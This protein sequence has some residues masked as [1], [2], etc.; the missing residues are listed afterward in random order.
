MRRYFE[1]IANQ[2]VAI[3]FEKK[4][5]MGV[6]W[7]ASTQYNDKFLYSSQSDEFSTLYSM[8]DGNGAWDVNA[9][10]TVN[11]DCTST[12]L[13]Y[14]YDTSYEFGYGNDVGAFLGSV[15]SGAGKWYC[16]GYVSRSDEGGPK[17]K[18]S[19]SI[20]DPLNGSLRVYETYDYYSGDIASGINDV[21]TS[22]NAVGF[23]GDDIIGGHGI[24]GGIWNTPVWSSLPQD[25]DYEEIQITGQ[26][27]TLYHCCVLGDGESV[28]A[29][30]SIDGIY[31]LSVSYVLLHGFN[32]VESATA[33]TY[34]LL[35][36]V[37][38]CNSST[39]SWYTFGYAEVSGQEIVFVTASHVFSP[40]P[41]WALSFIHSGWEEGPMYMTQDLDNVYILYG[42]WA[43]KGILCISKI[44]GT[45]VWDIVGDDSTC[46]IDAIKI[47]NGEL[48]ATGSASS[49]AAVIVASISTVDG[50]VNY[51]KQKVYSSGTYTCTEILEVSDGYAICG[52]VD[53]K[54]FII[55]NP[56]EI[57]DFTAASWGLS[58]ISR[59]YGSG[60]TFSTQ[61]YSSSRIDLNY[62]DIDSSI[63]NVVIS[64]L[65]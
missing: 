64:T 54:P 9:L 55:R 41:H 31:A 62:R 15:A 25:V 4:L 29:V 11:S 12:R 59:T 45:V 3:T 10:V 42:G 52:G 58:S 6:S 2:V 44:S 57:V 17:Y 32:R 35:S 63:N 22:G 30:G 13:N 49:G 61:P 16:G 23:C 46:N 38:A 33:P 26:T 37:L 51:I 60:V 39:T 19:L 1:A 65:S 14:W 20:I 50:S 5:D 27:I 7:P 8:G 36:G 56:D 47:V 24:I 48:I 21:S 53:G 43:N 34:S 40:T 18:P 28:V